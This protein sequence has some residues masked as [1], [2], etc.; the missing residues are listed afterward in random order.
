MSYIPGRLELDSHADTACI[1][2]NCQIVTYTE[3]VCQETP[4]HPDY[5]LIVDVLIVQAATAYTDLHTGKTYILII[6]KALYLRE[7]LKTSYL[8]PNN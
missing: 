5:E 1:R 4:Y 6:N 7:S 8:N 3:K 2:A